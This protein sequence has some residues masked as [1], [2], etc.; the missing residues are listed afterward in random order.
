MNEQ[1]AIE[2]LNQ[3]EVPMM[4]KGKNNEHLVVAHIKAI[5]ALEK[6]V[7]KKPIEI[8]RKHNFRGDVILLVGC[9][10]DCNSE[11]DSTYRYCKS[12]GSRLDWSVEE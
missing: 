9:C 11:L 5:E 8:R 4:L 10:A 2:L 12:C 1:E 3:E 6:Q 7:P